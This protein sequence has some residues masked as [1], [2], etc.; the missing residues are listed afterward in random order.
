MRF[1]KFSLT[2]LFVALSAF[3]LTLPGSPVTAAETASLGVGT[4]GGTYYVIGAGLAKVAEKYIPGFTLSIESTGGGNVPTR[5]IQAGKLDYGLATSGPMVW[6]AK[7]GYN[8]ELVKTY[9]NV[10]TLF[11]L[12]PNYF[13]YWAPET[14]G[15]KNFRDIAGK[16]FSGGPKTSVTSAFT[17]IWLKEFGLT[18]G[19]QV[20]AGMGELPALMLD[21]IIEVAAAA[22]GNPSGPAVETDS[23][24]PI[25]ILEFSDEDIDYITK[26]YPV[27]TRIMRP[28]GGYKNFPEP[29]P[30]LSMWGYCLANKDVSDD[31]AYQLTKVFFEHLEDFKAVY[32]P[33]LETKPEDVLTSPLPIHPGAVR[34]YKEVGVDIPE[35]LIAR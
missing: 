1:R 7:D 16:T 25:T 22:H 6:N 11:P 24:T 3:T 35:N 2:A 14:S 8:P 13:T 28:A 9:T 12:A 29:K 27:F 18:P 21:G 10:R 30:T 15:I 17:P 31:M 32:P 26:H 5:M 33:L 20:N 4:V 23:V 34:Y 19:K